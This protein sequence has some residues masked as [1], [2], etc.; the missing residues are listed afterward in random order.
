MSSSLALQLRGLAARPDGGAGPTAAVSDGSSR[1]S[2]LFTL[3]EAAALDLDDIFELGVNGLLE[4]A[5][6]DERFLSFQDS[7]FSPQARRTDREGQTPEENRTLN[8]RLADL[9]LLLSPHFM[10][11]AA[12]KVLEWLLRRF[13]IHRYN[14]FDVVAT[15][16]PFHDTAVW[17]RLVQ[18][19]PVA[20]T[21][22]AFLAGV[23]K[24]GAP[25][26]RSVLVERCLTPGGIDLLDFCFQVARKSLT[27]GIVNRPLCALW[28][29]LAVGAIRLRPV[30]ST[31][32]LVLPLGVQ[33]LRTPD[34]A[35][36]WDAGLMALLQ[37]ARS[38]RL[39]AD[40]A[41]VVAAAVAARAGDHEDALAVLCGVCTW[42]RGTLELDAAV[43]QQILRVPAALASAH[44]RLDTTPLVQ[45]LLQAVARE[46]TGTSTTALAPLW[47]TALPHIGAV[48]APAASQVVCSTLVGLANSSSNSS[49]DVAASV[50]AR[51]ANLWSHLGT[52]VG[53][54]V[55]AALAQSAFDKQLHAR[56]E[57]IALA[58]IGPVVTSY[59]PL[60]GTGT[61]VLLACTDSRAA[62]RMRALQCIDREV[63]AGRLAH[64]HQL[65]HAAA[66]L[67][68]DGDEAVACAA[69][70]LPW[71]TGAL[72]DSLWETLRPTI[73]SA[74]PGRA[75]ASVA[76]VEASLTVALRAHLAPAVDA[77]LSLCVDPTTGAVVAHIL[78]ACSRS[79]WTD[80]P[81]VAALAQASA[82]GHTSGS[83]RARTDTASMALEH[84]IVPLA[85]VL[86]RPVQPPLVWARVT[87]Q[88]APLAVMA[89]CTHLLLLDVDASS[90]V[91]EDATK[92][93]LLLLD[94]H[95][96][97]LHNNQPSAKRPRAPVDHAL[98]QLT[99]ALAARG[100]LASV[101]LLF[102]TLARAS[103][104]VSS[105]D[106]L[107]AL[108]ARLPD[109]GAFLRAAWSA[110]SYDVLVACRALQVADALLE[111][112]G[113]GACDAD[114]WLPSLLVP[115][116]AT[117]R[118]LRKPALRCACRLQGAGK[119][120]AF[121]LARISA[122]SADIA[123]SSDGLS[124]ALGTENQGVDKATLT[125]VVRWTL[126]QLAAQGPVSDT[127]LSMA[128]AS[129]TRLVLHADRI[130]G[131]LP[132]AQVALEAAPAHAALLLRS[133]AQPQ[134][135]PWLAKHGAAPVIA[136]AIA[137]ADE[138]VAQ[139][140]LDC[141][142]SALWSALRLDEQRLL[143]SALCGVVAAAA[144]LS[145]E[146]VEAALRVT[147]DVG[148]VRGAALLASQLRLQRGAETDVRGS[149]SKKARVA[150]PR[151]TDMTPEAV[152]AELAR[153]EVVLELVRASQGGDAVTAGALVA[154]LGDLG[155]L[156]DVAAADY[157]LQLSTV[158]LTALVANNRAQLNQDEVA[159][160]I[161]VLAHAQ[162]TPLL[163]KSLLALLGAAAAQQPHAVATQLVPLLTGAGGDD[164]GT[165][166][167][168][169][170][171]L[172]RVFPH[173]PL[174]QTAE[175]LNLLLGRLADMPAHRRLVL[176]VSAAKGLPQRPVADILVALLRPDATLLASAHESR[177]LAVSLCA[178]LGSLS[179]IEALQGLLTA[180]P[181][182]SHFAADCLTAT[183]FLNGM[184]GLA[185]EQEDQAQELLAAMFETLMHAITAPD[186]ESDSRVTEGLLE[187]LAAVNELF[188]IPR[189]LRVVKKLLSQASNEPRRRVLLVFNE[190]TA[191]H[192][193]YLTARE[194][195]RF[196]KMF[197]RLQRV[198]QDPGADE[199]LLQVVL[200]SLD[201]LGRSFATAHPEPVSRAL[202]CALGVANAHLA[203]SPILCA[204]A[205]LAASS[206]AAA[207]GQPALP[208]LG[209]ALQACCSAMDSSRPDL[210]YAA[211]SAA[212]RIVH[213]L[214][215]FLT[216]HTEALLEAATQPALLS[217]PRLGSRVTALCDQ[218]AVSVAPR[219]L[220]AALQ[221]LVKRSPSE[222][223]VA[224]VAIAAAASEETSRP[225]DL[226]LLWTCC[227]G[228]L[229]RTPALSAGATLAA[230]DAMAQVAFHLSEADFRPLLTA[231]LE[232]A[233]NCGDDQLEHSA[234]VYQV[235]GALVRRLKSIAVPW[236][237][238]LATVS[239]AS[240]ERAPLL[241]TDAEP[242]VRRHVL[243]A[244]DLWR[245]TFGADGEGAIS[246]DVHAALMEPIV[247]C[248]EAE[249][250]MAEAAECVMA[251][252]V[253]MDTDAL[254]RP[255]NHAILLRLRSA[256]SAVRAAT[257]QLVLDL[258]RRMGEAWL[259]MLPET[260]PF[261]GE[262]ME[263][264]NAAVVK[265]AQRWRKAVNALL[266][267]DE[268]VAFD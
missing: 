33:A 80:E 43:A 18:L 168:L 68:A 160:V 191:N 224:L 219:L 210:A 208:Y 15:T 69:L 225:A 193:P 66:L 234:A 119:G 24:T 151:T 171:V 94:S 138:S 70:E 172:D 37:L 221:A 97:S 241:A 127:P 202:Q 38:V 42:Q 187:A 51:L 181:S 124:L 78:R 4:L 227:A 154:L 229:Y 200:L 132:R 84:L 98:S 48:A 232:S 86:C 120:V 137:H 217:H 174:D 220:A 83:K 58:V 117:Q 242:R 136:A 236:V 143:L 14:L 196:V 237:C 5:R 205:L 9:L 212:L 135:A 56:V 206:L 1:P 91:A 112:R 79:G 268:G 198:V 178:E 146:R 263:D 2:L 145:A 254:W 17:A 123:S 257:M 13:L 214:G 180:L 258:W 255:L 239:V 155:S 6:S 190:R 149:S 11:R 204:S 207:L 131:L 133:F 87:A 159:V 110:P 260:L 129:A 177:S 50:A 65:A 201:V 57:R 152:L 26:P 230:A 244:L 73:L 199:P 55:A 166:A 74:A 105:A 32:K 240:L 184:L 173:V 67:C 101:E 249:S 141:L 76:R 148:A 140:A 267:P 156:E 176:L 250:I 46:V 211:L 111:A 235:F 34:A 12:H 195:R 19:L 61:T 40:A 169:R 233:A 96:A 104:A 41:G 253:C 126:E 185:P 64:H 248:L 226:R 163:R 72:G 106:P 100:S 134:C 82:D 99:E 216:T 183:W 167:V 114:L 157:T 102:A 81:I 188:S 130:K 59:S 189:F 259:A 251:M 162:R 222:T 261:V 45:C 223:V 39:S 252:A 147:R 49:G 107:L 88:L 89:L 228:A 20:D 218:V 63:S 115:L 53:D 118:A 238:R 35:A 266:P 128:L 203:S 62:V 90:T 243:A 27:R 95:L 103:A 108:L 25:L 142:S 122:C 231:L 113:A 175:L 54:G 213:S 161:H 265:A 264:D 262:A 85:A 44:R 36:L 8:G 245:V 52:S 109:V 139:A 150:A 92:H 165:F 23:R 215:K 29:S 170:G 164:R 31:V 60:E 153:L 182:A 47:Q 22:F 121:V 194:E 7:L 10:A 75:S 21:A 116:Q 77:V 28:A 179:T 16:L 197:P 247:G 71:I 93:G 256:R 246:K 186:T 125:A 192:R 144:S 158:A 30:E 209:T 3:R